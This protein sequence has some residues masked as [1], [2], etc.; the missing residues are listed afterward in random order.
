VAPELV[1]SGIPN[2]KMVKLTVYMGVL[3]VAFPMTKVDRGIKLLIEPAANN[4]KCDQFSVNK[5]QQNVP[6]VVC[7]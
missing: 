5:T 4:P 2:D 6:H 7:Q 1:A 3:I